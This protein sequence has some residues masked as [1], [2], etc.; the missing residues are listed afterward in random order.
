MGPH[1]PGSCEVEQLE[2]Q[3]LARLSGRVR[4]LRLLA[5]DQ[6]LI[7]RGRV[8]TYY[9]KQLAQHAVMTATALPILANEIEVG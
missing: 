6:G 4:N 3:V 1:A 5:Q 2:T 8:P 7:L 9:A